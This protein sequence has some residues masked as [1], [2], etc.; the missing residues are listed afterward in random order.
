MN[1]NN[2]NISNFLVLNL[3]K[4]INDEETV[5]QGTS[6]FIPLIATALAMEKKK[7]DLIGGFSSNPEITPKIPSTFSFKN[8]KNE[9]SYLGL[10][11]FLDL[12]QNNKIHLEFLRP[13]QI[14]KFGNINNTV[15]GNHKKLKVRLPGGM[16]VDD[17]M[18]FIR[19]II[20]YIPNHNDKI[21]VNKVDFVTAS[22]WNKGKG[23]NKIITNMCVFEFIN[24]KIV[25]TE[26]NHKYSIDDIK[27]NTGFKF[28]IAS[29]INNML[30]VDVKTKELI[31][32][33]DPLSLRDLE[34]KDKRKEVLAKFR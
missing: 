3:S 17:V 18:H 12:L 30:Q 1:Q 5:V 4:E 14:D 7:I 32:K 6:T 15:I 21:L 25:L 31:N 33:L 27:K 13:A 19:K 8:Y 28:K 16:G 2:F 9:K 34:I 22:G 26:I 23:P 24:K 29:K 10:S 20:I 11:G